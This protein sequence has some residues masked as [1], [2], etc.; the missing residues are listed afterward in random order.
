MRP[1][2]SYLALALQAA[3]GASNITLINQ[4]TIDA[5]LGMALP[6]GGTSWGLWRTNPD[7]SIQL[8]ASNLHVNE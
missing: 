8:L 3:T 6:G 2:I 1:R 5:L 7:G 4:G